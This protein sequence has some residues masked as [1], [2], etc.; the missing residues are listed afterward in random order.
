[1]LEDELDRLRETI[2]H[3]AQ[4]LFSLMGVRP[5]IQLDV[6]S[7]VRTTCI[8]LV[9]CGLGGHPKPAIDRHLKTGHHT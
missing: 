6:P 9:C 5:A 8:R 2:L 3:K 7:G 4:S 1:M